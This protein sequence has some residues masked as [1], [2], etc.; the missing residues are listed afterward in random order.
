MTFATAYYVT[1]KSSLLLN[2]LYPY[3]VELN[4]VRRHLLSDPATT[5]KAIH[6]ASAARL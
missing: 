5:A 4:Q 1:Y 6:Q 2:S 3:E